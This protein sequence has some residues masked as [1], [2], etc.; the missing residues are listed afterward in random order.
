MPM[1]G[2]D[3]ERP[4]PHRQGREAAD[5]AGL[6][7]MGV[8]NVRSEPARECDQPGQRQAVLIGPHR[9]QKRRDELGP[10]VL[11]LGQGCHRR[12]AGGQRAMH[13]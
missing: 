10:G 6:C 2:V 4:R 11:S 12:L 9:L 3:D 1:K 13:E 7:R 5:E 8:D